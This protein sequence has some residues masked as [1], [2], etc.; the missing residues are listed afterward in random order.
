M[1]INLTL[2]VQ[3]INFGI[4]YK[5]ITHYFLREALAV[6]NDEEKIKAETQR[7]LKEE[8]KIIEQ[9]REIKKNLWKNFQNFFNSKK[10]VIF[11]A[12]PATTVNSI[13]I[14]GVII[15]KK[16]DLLATDIV[17]DLREKI[18]E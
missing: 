1:N 14:N 16:I 11:N 18:I 5:V 3:A 12:S 13:K 10:P 6:V 2:I 15:P 17:N 8:N 4:A 7:Q 9:K